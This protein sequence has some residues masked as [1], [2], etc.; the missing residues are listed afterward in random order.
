MTYKPT[1]LPDGRKAYNPNRTERDIAEEWQALEDKLKADGVTDP[2]ALHMQSRELWR[3]E[4][5][6][7]E[8][9]R[10]WQ[11]R[12]WFPACRAAS[13]AEPERSLDFTKEELERLA[14]HFANA[15]DPVAIAI[16]SKASL[17]LAEWDK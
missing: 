11:Q 1:F 12:V 13:N 10:D 6:H 14:E 15:N 2:I 3:Q 4:E 9:W 16:H 5:A 17:A 8:P 7:A